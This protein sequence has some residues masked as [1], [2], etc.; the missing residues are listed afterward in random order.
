[1]DR[2]NNWERTQCAYNAIAK[3]EGKKYDSAFEAIRGSYEAGK[4]DE[5]IEPCV[6][7]AANGKT[8][9]VTDH[10]AMIFLN[11]RSDRARQLAKKFTEECHTEDFTYITM[12]D[13]G[14]SSPKN[15][16]FGGKI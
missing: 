10:D 7:P 9:E 13:Y 6:L 5:F 14:G 2:D 16:L 3:R 11:F 8:C 15:V 12:T 1:M 4:T